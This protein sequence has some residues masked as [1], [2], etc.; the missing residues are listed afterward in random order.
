[1]RI[2]FKELLAISLVFLP[3]A[4]AA[5]EALAPSS[6]WAV[7]YGTDHCMLYR[8]F[9]EGDDA[10]L[11]QFSQY[12]P[13]GGLKIIVAGKKLNSRPTQ[14]LHSRFEPEQ[15]PSIDEAPVFATFGDGLKGIILMRPLRRMEVYGQL[16]KSAQTIR[17]PA[18]LAEMMAWPDAQREERE[19]EITHF[20]IERGFTR[21]VRLRVGSMKK[22]MDAMRACLDE[23]ISKS[24]PDFGSSQMDRT[25][26]LSGRA[27]A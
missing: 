24:H 21:P 20:T 15:E 12:V 13:D 23:L 22:P 18:K 14:A 6:N 26:R 10:V 7:D 16:L 9:G 25:R 5:Q 4:V 2:I 1:M 11:L 19:E 27:A 3:V 8:N 17:D